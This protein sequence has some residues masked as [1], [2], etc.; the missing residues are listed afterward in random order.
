MEGKVRR[1]TSSSMFMIGHGQAE[2]DVLEESASCQGEQMG[3]EEDW[4][5]AVQGCAG[6]GRP[7]H[8]GG[9]VSLDSVLDNLSMLSLPYTKNETFPE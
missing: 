9:P 4:I 3:V 8:S 6:L 2:I 7:G 5:G 1:G